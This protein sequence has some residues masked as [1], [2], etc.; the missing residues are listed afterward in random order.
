MSA[1]RAVLGGVCAGIADYFGFN[2]RVLRFLAVIAF[3][4]AMP[5]AVIA[6]LAIV[7]LVPARAGS[8]YESSHRESERDSRATRK[9]RT[10]RKYRKAC[11]KERKYERRRAREEAKLQE[12]ERPTQAANEV[13][14]KCQALEQRLV[15]LEKHITSSQ[16]QLDR[17]IRNL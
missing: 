9:S 1:Y 15:D 16:Y 14:S 5:F 11:R 10:Y 8:R 2:L 13:R 17:E 7:M 6:Y 4:F 12:Q 3:L